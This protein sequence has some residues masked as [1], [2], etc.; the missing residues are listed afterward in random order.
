[1]A[2]RPRDHRAKQGGPHG[3][4]AAPATSTPHAPLPLRTRFLPG[5]HTHGFTRPGSC[6]LSCSHVFETVH[7]LCT[8][9]LHAFSS[10][11]GTRLRRRVTT[12]ESLLLAAWWT[13][14]LHL[15]RDT[16]TARLRGA[17]AGAVGVSR[18]AER[19]PAPTGGGESA[20]TASSSLSGAHH[21]PRVL[22]A[23]AFCEASAGSRC[24]YL[25]VIR[26]LTMGA[27]G[28]A[29]LRSPRE[30]S[31]DRWIIY[32]TNEDSDPGGRETSRSQA[33]SQ[34]SIKTDTDWRTASP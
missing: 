16:D 31:R 25:A 4:C 7:R 20:P 29:H 23:P 3:A 17:Q 13:T 27:L 6:L 5:F 2:H 11:K 15:S 32:I 30:R 34:K 12:H 28:P 1:M 22:A 10:P 21:G 19:F 9:V 14:R 8:S 33:Q 24:S 26:F 18:R